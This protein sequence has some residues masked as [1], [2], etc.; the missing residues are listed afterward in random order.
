MVRTTPGT[1][2]SRSREPTRGTG[3]GGLANVFRS[4]TSRS[5]SR[6]PAHGTGRGGYGNA[7]L[8][9][10]L[11]KDIMEVDEAERAAH[12]HPPGVYVP[13]S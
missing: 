12:L 4:S 9:E 6:E 11:E 8:G 5:R 7:Y 3:L 1:S 2:R 10:P 13:N